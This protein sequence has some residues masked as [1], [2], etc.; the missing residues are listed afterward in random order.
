MNAIV[1]V[2][3]VLTPYIDTQAQE[4]SRKSCYQDWLVLL[5]C[6]ATSHHSGV[7]IVMLCPFCLYNSCLLWPRSLLVKSDTA[8][9]R[10]YA[11]SP[12]SLYFL[13]SIDL[14]EEPKDPCGLCPDPFLPESSL[15]EPF[16]SVFSGVCELLSCALLWLRN[17]SCNLT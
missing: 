8:K 11:R 15:L 14:Q 7:S 1:R 5:F 10:R 17:V 4:D 3:Y 12:S 6:I 9:T 2:L 13:V 16:L